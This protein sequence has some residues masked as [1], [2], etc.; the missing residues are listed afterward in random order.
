MHILKKAPE[1]PEASSKRLMPVLTKSPKL[2][3]YLPDWEAGQREPNRDWLWTLLFAVDPKFGKALLNEI[4]DI[5]GR[6]AQLNAKKERKQ[7]Q[8]DEKVA[9]ELLADPALQCKS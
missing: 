6:L 4:I 1:W 8:V 3:R 5:R 9:R 2:R 7:I